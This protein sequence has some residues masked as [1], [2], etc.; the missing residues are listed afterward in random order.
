MELFSLTGK[1]AVITG[2][3]RGLGRHM[4]AGLA[5]AGAHVVLIA[6]DA[7]RL[8][9][10]RDEI[11]RGGGKASM[12]P[13]DLGDVS[14]IRPAVERIAAEQGRIDICVNNAGI[15]DWQPLADSTLESLD[16]ILGLNVKATFKMSQACAA[17]MRNGGAGG[18]IVNIGSVL[19]TIGRA[20]LHAYCA[21]KS[22]IVGL[23]RSLASELGRD[24][25]TANVIAPG[26]FA[27]DINASLTARPGYR[28]AV[29]GVT[30]MERWGDPKE[31]VGT[32]IYLA[33]AASS[34][35]TGQVIH[36]DGGISATFK[37]ELGAA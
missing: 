22:A 18:R 15:I 4:A 21:S 2:A 30:P 10:L 8:A 7:D 6:R 14:A 26:Y 9:E 3:S 33:S 20:K 36:V 5:Q 31:L 37:F 19:S 16:A 12:M 27:S 28:E 32:L 17:I 34:Y 24:G 23:T 35:T 29:E 1:V 25:I 11:V 13:L